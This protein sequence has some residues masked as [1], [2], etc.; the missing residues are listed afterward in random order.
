MFTFVSLLRSD[1]E[2]GPLGAV[3]LSNGVE[4]CIR[5]QEHLCNHKAKVPT[6]IKTFIAYQ[7]QQPG[8]AANVAAAYVRS[9]N[10]Q[11]LCSIRNK[12]KKNSEKSQKR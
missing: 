11:I 12:E 4:K 1:A 9:T 2:R 7:P 8:C 10:K 6:D 5:Y 3:C